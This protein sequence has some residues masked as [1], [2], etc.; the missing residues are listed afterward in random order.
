MEVEF[1]ARIRRTVARLIV[2]LNKIDTLDPDERETATTFLRRVL[3]EQVGLDPATPIF[4][5]SSRQN[6]R[7]RLTGNVEALDGSGIAELQTYLMQFLA[8]ERRSTLRAAVAR[9]AAILVGGTYVINHPLPI[10]ILVIF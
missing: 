1:L 8:H 10:E 7:A 3:L 2:V 6:L 5:L 4:C 9:K